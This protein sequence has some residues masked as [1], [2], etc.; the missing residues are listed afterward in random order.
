MRSF[1][2]IVSTVFLFAVALAAGHSHAKD[3]M[4]KL[5]IEGRGDITLKLSDRAPKATSQILRLIRAG[6]YDGQRFHRVDR[7]PKP[8]L[9]QIG[10]PASKDGEL[11]GNGGSGSQVPYEDSGLPN[12]AGAVGLAHPIDQ[13]E[14]G[15][16]QFYILLDNAGFLDGKY[17]VFGQVTAGMDV[18]KKI[19][20]GDRVIRVTVVNG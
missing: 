11:N 7:T 6:F 3:T 5:E 10:D 1:L 16:S 20:R 17:T 8:F 9:V 15:D 14:K 12:V 2:L 4:V 19:Q 18:L 13:P